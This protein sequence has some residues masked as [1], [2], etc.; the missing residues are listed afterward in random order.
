MDKETIQAALYAEFVRKYQA[1]ARLDPIKPKN[2]IGRMLSDRWMMDRYS[3][4]RERQWLDYI[5]ARD[6]YLEFLYHPPQGAG[7][8]VR[9]PAECGGNRA[10]V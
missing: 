2:T 10:K 7:L 5:I 4:G 3:S 8:S 6:N 1:W 9:T